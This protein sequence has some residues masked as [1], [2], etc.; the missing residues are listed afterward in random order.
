MDAGWLKRNVHWASMN[1][2]T[3][4]GELRCD[5][6][7][8]LA[9][10]TVLPKSEVAPN[11]TTAPNARVS[12]ATTALMVPPTRIPTTPVS[13]RQVVPVLLAMLLMFFLARTQQTRMRF[14]MVTAMVLLLVLA[15]CG[16]GKAPGTTKG[17]ATLTITGTSTT[18]ALTHTV[19]VNI[20]VN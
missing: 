4:G 8:T 17:P 18:P 11:G 6:A 20:S 15:G 3:G 12:L 2:Y 7:A 16:G 10:C 5:G 19:Q 14:G 13:I 1:G 9:T